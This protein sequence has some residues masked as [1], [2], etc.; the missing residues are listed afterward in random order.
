[1]GQEC[2][3]LAREIGDFAAVK[4]CAAEKEHAACQER[5]A[6]CPLYRTMAKWKQWGIPERERKLLR[7]DLLGNKLLV[8]RLALQAMNARIARKSGPQ[9]MKGSE[10][11]VV[12]AGKCREGKTVAA[13]WALSRTGGQYVTACQF[14]GI[15]LDLATLKNGNT[16][17]IDQLGTEPIGASEWALGQ[18]LDVIDSRYANLRLTVLCTNMLRETLESRYTRILGRRLHDDGIFIRLGDAS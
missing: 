6:F 14:A 7:E 2:K 3:R 11:L 10:S 1:M 13:T 9:G 5:A 15:G 12:L 17:V 4:R 18:L 8:P 16:L